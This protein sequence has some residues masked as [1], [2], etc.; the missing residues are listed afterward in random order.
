M[1]ERHRTD[2]TGRR[3][4]GGWGESDAESPRLRRP[5]QWT[6]EVL[7]EAP[8]PRVWIA[9][10][11][12]TLIPGYHPDV[13]EVELLSGERRRAPGVAYKCIVPDGLRSGWCIER[14][15]EHVPYE[16]TTVDFPD[17]SWGIGRW[18]DGFLA[19]VDVSPRGLDATLVRLRAFYA[20]KGPIARILNVLLRPMMRRRAR[21]TLQGLKRLVEGGS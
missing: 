21:L 18:L 3:R 16:R 9:V 17:D 8:V 20:P 14:V 12:L 6:A 10:E 15:V 13:E 7:V 1:K 19:E 5:L 11:D 2:P 4:F